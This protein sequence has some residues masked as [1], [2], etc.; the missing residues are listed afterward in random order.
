M[1]YFTQLTNIEEHLGKFA[2]C[3]NLIKATASAAESSSI[4]DQEV[5]DILWHIH[6]KMDEAYVDV[7]EAF[8][9]LFD[10]LK[11]KGSS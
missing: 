11:N 9:T 3:E 4:D 1:D 10:S 7:Y 6:A 8:Q 2:T 5:A